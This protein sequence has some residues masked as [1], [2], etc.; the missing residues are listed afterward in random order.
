MRVFAPVPLCLSPVYETGGL[1]WLPSSKLIPV[2]RGV[3]HH[4]HR[5]LE[6]SGSSAKRNMTGGV[7]GLGPRLG[8][9]R[10]PDLAGTF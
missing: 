1:H 5:P 4:G 6:R 2:F 9:A 8:Q 3:F 7:P 10:I